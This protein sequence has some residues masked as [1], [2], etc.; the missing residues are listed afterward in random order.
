MKND[1]EDK[2]LEVLSDKQ[3]TEAPLREV[4]KHLYF[5]VIQSQVIETNLRAEL[6]K[7]NKKLSRVEDALSSIMFIRSGFLKI[8]YNHRTS[9][10]TVEKYYRIDFGDTIENDLLKTMFYQ[11]SG[12]PRPAKWQ[13]SEVAES[14]RKKGNESLDDPRAIYKAAHRIK[15]RLHKE[16]KIDVLYVKGKEFFWYYP[17]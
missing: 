12:K 5:Q 4:I 9:E 1:E 7:T 15:T 11:K 17:N 6:A 14:F 16:L 13:C 10:V 8:R 2:L 3:F